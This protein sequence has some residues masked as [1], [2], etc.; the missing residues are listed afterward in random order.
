MS[1][2]SALNASN[3]RDLPL[4]EFTHAAT[5]LTSD[6]YA[7]AWALV[8]YL[9]EI[10]P[11]GRLVMFDYIAYHCGLCKEMGRGK[12]PPGFSL[13]DT[14]ELNGRNLPDFEQEFLGY[15]RGE[16]DPR[17]PGKRKARR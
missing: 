7:Q 6:F 14:L 5:E 4:A 12:R 3:S 1:P 8:Y 15:F 10:D 13:A 16:S 11:T 17:K 2:S 9:M